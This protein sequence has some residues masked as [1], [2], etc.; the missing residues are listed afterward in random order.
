[1]KKI[2]HTFSIIV[3]TLSLVGCNFSTEET[4]TDDKAQQKP[5]KL[6]NF[7]MTPNHKEVRVFTDSMQLDGLFPEKIIVEM[8]YYETRPIEGKLREISRG[9]LVF[10]DTKNLFPSGFG[11]AIGRIVALPG[12]T[13]EVDKGQVY[14]NDKKLDTFYGHEYNWPSKNPEDGLNAEKTDT[15]SKEKFTVQQ[16]HYLILGDNWWRNPLGV[17]SKNRTT[18]NPIPKEY[19][20]GKVIGYQDPKPWAVSPVFHV[21]NDTLRGIEG[22]IGLI[23]KPFIVNQTDEYTWRL[24]GKPE[25]LANKKFKVIA[26]RENGDGAFFEEVPIPLRHSG[27]TTAITSIPYTMKLIDKGLY[28][29]DAYVDNQLFGSVTVNVE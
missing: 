11:T 13:V 25:D 4:I 5:P 18:F 29:L 28:R 10:L 16:D 14:I 26:N 7:N 20:K 6:V 2:I 12:E 27:S 3:L 21:A 1:M 9:D 22:K 8:D 19:I 17:N 15:V 23:E 24:W